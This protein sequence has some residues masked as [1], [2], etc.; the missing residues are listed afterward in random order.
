MVKIKLNALEGTSKKEI[1]LRQIKALADEVDKARNQADTAIS[2]ALDKYWELGKQI[3]ENESTLGTQEQIAR[4]IGWKQQ[5]VSEAVRIYK[6]YPSGLPD[7]WKRISLK[8]I[9]H[10][11]LPDHARVE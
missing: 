4:A 6:S 9:V 7:K 8:E 5:R 2:S 11:A 3:D 1:L 10:R